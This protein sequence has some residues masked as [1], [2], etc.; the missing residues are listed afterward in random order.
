MRKPALQQV[1]FGDP[2]KTPFVRFDLGVLY[3][4]N[5][6][7]Q[8]TETVLGGLGTS[9]IAELLGRLIRKGQVGGTFGVLCESTWFALIQNFL[10]YHTE[11]VADVEQ[12]EAYCLEALKIMVRRP[13]EE[14]WPVLRQFIVRNADNLS[15]W[16]TSFRKHHAEEWAV[17]RGQDGNYYYRNQEK[18]IVQI[19]GAKPT[20]ET[21]LDFITDQLVFS[22]GFLH[23]FL[24]MFSLFAIADDF[25]RNPHE[26]HRLIKASLPDPKYRPVSVSWTFMHSDHSRTYRWRPHSNMC[27]PGW[28]VGDVLGELTDTLEIDNWLRH[29][30][31]TKTDQDWLDDGCKFQMDYA[32]DT[33]V[34]VGTAPC[35]YI[36][37]DG[38]VIRWINGTPERD[39]TVSISVESLQNHSNEDEKLNRFLSL[40]VWD[41]RHPAGIRTGV[42]GG[43]T[44][45]SKAY[46][47]R[48]AASLRIEPTD[49]Q[50]LFAKARNAKQRLALALYREA[51]NSSSTFYE[52]LSYWRILEVGLGASA[53]KR[54]TWLEK[55]AIPKLGYEERLKEVV[56]KH[57]DLEKYLR[58]TRA[59]AIKHAIKGEIDP[60]DP[61]D[62][63]AN[64]RDN[65]FMEEI[66]R[67]VMTDVLKL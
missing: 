31:P 21:R 64:T 37:F 41:H 22:T 62:R 38:K 60:D 11:A 9:N 15:G 32:L 34:R 24:S 12:A 50:A 57:P 40:M 47:P 8:A 61:K 4:P 5:K 51:T 6:I 45:Y 25:D 35:V 58:E 18:E 49:L 44:A 33:S 42:G 39:A 16:D 43:R 27:D 13:H 2:G 63:L 19:I 28:L 56:A 14:A 46:S 29:A 36:P 1:D 52:F 67:L 54:R 17:F 20:E 26:Y 3:P 10:T 65:F 59:N 48:R 30:D 55:V 23:Q 7:Y 66:A 53:T